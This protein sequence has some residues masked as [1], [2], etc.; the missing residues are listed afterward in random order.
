[1]ASLKKKPLRGFSFKI[2]Q[3]LTQVFYIDYRGHTVSPISSI[4][5]ERTCDGANDKWQNKKGKG[6]SEDNQRPGDFCLVIFGGLSERVRRRNA[7]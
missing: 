7:D 5:F 6:E 3:R 4:K 2:F 1:M